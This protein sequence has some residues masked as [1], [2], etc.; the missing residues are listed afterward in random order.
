MEEIYYKNKNAVAILRVSSRKQN[1]GISHEVQEKKCREYCEEQ[2]LNLIKFFIFTESAKRSEDRKKYHEAMAFIKKNKHFNV[3][4]YAQD[5]ETRN[6]R[7]LT[8]NEED[9]LD[10][11]FNIHYVTN[12]KILH[13]DSPDSDFFSRDINGAV[14]RHHCRDLR[15]KVKDAME[16]KAES[17]WFPSGVPPLGYVC[18]KSIN[19][20]TGRIRKRGGTIGVDPNEINIKIVRREFELRANGLSYEEIRKTVLAEGLITGKKARAYRKGTI[21]G[22]INNPF[23]RGNFMWDGKLYQGKHSVFIKKEHLDKVDS[24]SG[25]WGFKRR[26][27]SS[28][29]TAITDGWLRCECGCKIIYDPKEKI[30]K[31]TGDIKKYHYYRCTNGKRTHEKLVNINAPKIWEQFS[32][33]MDEI[34]ISEDFAEVIAQALNATEKKAHKAIE[35]QIDGFKLNLKELETHENKLFDLRIAG[36]INQEDFEK[37][38]SRIRTNRDELTNQLEALQKG[39]TTAMM[40]TAKTVLELAKNAKSLWNTMAAED[41]RVLLDKLLSNPILDGLNV[42]FNLKKPFAV[43]VQMKEN[44]EWCR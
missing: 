14:A 35:M 1:D 28:E 11:V 9:V 5:R 34:N 42:R 31:T 20:E 39:L 30:N 25:K 6:L 32:A 15:T 26:N 3:I 29:F 7:D 12:R 37:Q 13:Q 10:G 40:E 2:K 17:G 22:R 36:N 8:D 23:Y 16:V 43:L 38:L 19:E 33:V 41:R 21:E 4:F 24:L 18:I 44:E 27:F